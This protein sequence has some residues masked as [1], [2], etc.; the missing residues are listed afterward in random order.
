[1][2]TVPTYHGERNRINCFKFSG[3]R[4]LEFF[5]YPLL[6]LN[7]ARNSDQP[8]EGLKRGIIIWKLH[9]ES[10]NIPY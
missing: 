6:N 5:D 8:N 1:M 9:P 10:A 2:P 4:L 3:K 7:K